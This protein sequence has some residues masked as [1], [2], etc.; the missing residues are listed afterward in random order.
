MREGVQYRCL[1]KKDDLGVEVNLKCS[2]FKQIPHNLKSIEKSGKCLNI[3]D[4]K[5]EDCGK[6]KRI[7]M[8]QDY[9]KNQLD[10]YGSSAYAIG[11]VLAASA[12][13]G[14]YNRVYSKTGVLS[15]TKGKERSVKSVRTEMCNR[16]KKVL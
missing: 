14:V 9:F 10:E 15:K 3:A 13:K 4:S 16:T 12:T 1:H 11:S 6:V 7:E 5:L 8:G 2:L